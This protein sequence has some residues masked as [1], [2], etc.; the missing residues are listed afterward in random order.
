MDHPVVREDLEMIY[1]SEEVGWGNLSG[2]SFLITGAT[3]MLLSYLVFFL[4]HLNECKQ[5]PIEIYIFVRSENKAKRIFGDYLTKKYI[6]LVFGDLCEEFSLEMDVDYIIHGASITSPQ[7]YETNPV[8][9]LLPN[10]L[11]TY[12]L[13][14]YAR[15]HPVLNFLFLSSG[16]VYGNQIGDSVVRETDGGWVD[17]LSTKACYSESKRMGETMCLAWFR[18]YHIPTRIVRIRHT[19]G[20]TMNLQNDDRSFSY[21]FNCLMRG[22][23]IVLNS[24]GSEEVEFLYISDAIKGILRILLRG[25]DGEAYNLGNSKERIAIS[26]LAELIL[27]FEPDKQLQVIKP[28]GMPSK[29]GLKRRTDTSKLEKLGWNPQV[30]IKTGFNRT[31]EALTPMRDYSTI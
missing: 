22:N 23:D 4:I 3:G 9:T 2:K 15:K 20:P 19:Y 6:H 25:Q 17:P 11:G 16:A 13:L 24:D 27:S 1:K 29:H 12:Q 21:F 14:E 18:Q 7:Y 28:Q 10:V 31:Y 30:S 8:E 26:K 5:I